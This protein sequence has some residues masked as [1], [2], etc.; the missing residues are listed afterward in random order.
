MMFWI[1]FAAGIVTAVIAV[2]VWIF[3]EVSEDERAELNGL[4]TQEELAAFRYYWRYHT[5][6]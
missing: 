1:G 6:P 2:T 3:W 5:Q 4:M